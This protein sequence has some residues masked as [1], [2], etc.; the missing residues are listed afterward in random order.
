MGSFPRA[1]SLKNERAP[2]LCIPDAR[3]SHGRLKDET[4]ASSQDQAIERWSGCSYAIAVGSTIKDIPVAITH[5]PRPS[6]PVTIQILCGLQEFYRV[7][8]PLYLQNHPD[9]KGAVPGDATSAP[10]GGLLA[11][12]ASSQSAPRLPWRV[13]R[14]VPTFGRTV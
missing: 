11:C 9:P 13:S 14:S 7:S 12:V 4:E 3:I 5:P 6:G 2:G 1:A 8:C 10:C